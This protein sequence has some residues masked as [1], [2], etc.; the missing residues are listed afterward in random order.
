MTE[1]QGEAEDQEIRHLHPHGQ[2]LG[3][4]NVPVRMNH[5]CRRQPVGQDH[6]QEV[7]HF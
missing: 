6:E 5:E 1:E 4:R 3:E 2:K 7:K